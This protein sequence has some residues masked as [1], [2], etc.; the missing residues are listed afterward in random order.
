[1]RMAFS[2]IGIVP[3]I[4]HPLTRP[5]SVAS[6]GN[7]IS[8][9]YVPSAQPV[10]HDLARGVRRQLV[11]ELYIP[12]HLVSGHSLPT[13]GDECVGGGRLDGV[14]PADHERLSHLTHPIVRYADDGDLRDRR[15]LEQEAFD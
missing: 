6:C 2:I 5:E 11:E 7:A 4:P 9:L 13:P 15:V 3:T 10:L 1:M 14:A 12:G 8:A